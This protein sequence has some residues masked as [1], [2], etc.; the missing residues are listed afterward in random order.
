[1][2]IY[3]ILSRGELKN[4][5][6][7]IVDKNK[8]LALD[9]F[10]GN[11]LFEKIK[12]LNLQLVG[13]INTHQHEDHICGND[14]LQRLSDCKIFDSLEDQQIIKLNQLELKILNT[15]GHTANDISVLLSLKGKPYAIF[16]GDTLFN[17][18]VGNCHSGDVNLLFN[19]IDQIYQKLPDQILIYPGHDYF[20]KNLKF[21]LS[22]EPDNEFVKKYLAN[23][24]EEITT[25]EIEKK[26]NPF[27]R[28][29]NINI[30]GSSQ[31]VF[32][33]LRKL[34]DRF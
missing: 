23:N 21:S 7:L 4:Y 17:A 10:D 18:G 13:I 1:M 33:Q 28:L 9:P 15:P 8:A 31:E 19:S 6:Y 5:S 26:I 25:L 16:T 14:S 27:L 12:S 32:K 22:V 20:E 29:E 34:R 11:E 24:C 2:K 3:Q 30:Q